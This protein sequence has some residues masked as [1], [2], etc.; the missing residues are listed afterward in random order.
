MQGIFF[1]IP[2][3]KTQFQQIFRM[4]LPGEMI[5]KGAIKGHVTCLVVT[6]VFIETVHIHVEVKPFSQA[7]SIVDIHH[8]HHFIL[9]YE[10][11]AAL[12]NR[13]PC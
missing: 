2:K 5:D 11:S 10:C 4:K 8:L 13:T 12:Q 3:M 1:V 6:Q 9:F 7:A